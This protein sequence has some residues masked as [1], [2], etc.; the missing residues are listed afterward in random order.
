MIFK[1]RLLLISLSL[2]FPI[3]FAYFNRYVTIF[4]LLNYLCFYW[5]FYWIFIILYGC[6]Y[7]YEMCFIFI[8]NRKSVICQK[9]TAN[10]CQLVNPAWLRNVAQHFVPLWEGNFWVH[11]DLALAP[12][13]GH[14]A[15]TKVSSFAVHLDAL[16]QEL[17]LKAYMIQKNHTE[18]WLVH[19]P[20]WL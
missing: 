4:P 16:L 20:P 12:F 15:A 1:K 6:I 8:I 18:Q 19:E 2:W 10:S 11:S 13:Y 5:F 17:L 14:H 7:V 3:C 9:N